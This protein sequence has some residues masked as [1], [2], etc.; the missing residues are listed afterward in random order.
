MRQSNDTLLIQT[1]PP[2]SIPLP[3]T[4]QTESS[5]Q[6]ETQVGRDG[7][8]IPNSNKTEDTIP[9]VEFDDDVYLKSIQNN[10]ACRRE[11]SLKVMMQLNPSY[12][13][14]NVPDNNSTGV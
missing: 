4:R 12:F 9:Y 11:G 14:T 8:F 3:L 13:E 2:Y 7:Y 6:K 1:M 10:M 5:T